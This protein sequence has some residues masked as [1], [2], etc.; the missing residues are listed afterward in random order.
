M[1]ELAI[2]DNQIYICIGLVVLLFLFSRIKLGLS[3]AF[4]F[5]FYWG[6]IENKD[7]FF[8]NLETSSPYVLLYFI[9][10]IVLIVFTLLSFMFSE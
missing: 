5:T 7:L 9:S 3:L 8:V 1:M 2:P 10:G 4:C 6:F